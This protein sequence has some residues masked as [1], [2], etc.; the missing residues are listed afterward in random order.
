MWTIKK[1]VSKGDYN[2][3]VCPDH[4]NATKNGYVLEH[5]IVMENYLGRVLGSREVVHHK[6]K[7][8]KDNKIENLEL[9]TATEHAR[10]HGSEKGRRVAR[11]SCPQCKTKFTRKYSSTHLSRKNQSA[12]FCSKKC[13]SKFYRQ[14]ELYGEDYAM[15]EAVSSSVVCVFYEY[16]KS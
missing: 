12:T 15:K 10:H 13:S 8:K 9:M 3:A 5:R 16:D 4:P 14:I 6:N 11:I 1:I 7:N 2:Y